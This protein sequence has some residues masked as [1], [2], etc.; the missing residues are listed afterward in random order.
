MMRNGADVLIEGY[1]S[2]FG[3]EDLAGDVVRAGAFA[4]TLAAGAATSMLLQHRGG[5]VAGVWT[6]LRED[7]RGLF[8]RGL[9]RADTAAGRSALRLIGGG[10]LDGL[11]IGFVARE[12]SPRLARGRDL[13]VLELR[14][15]SLVASPMAPEARFRTVTPVQRNMIAA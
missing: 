7:G 9:V 6:T 15:I 10:V 2:L 8:A 5:Q 3:V 14:E 13:K 11:S 12:W 4:R 1:A